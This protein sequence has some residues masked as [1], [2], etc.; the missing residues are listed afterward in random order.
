MKNILVPTDFSIFAKYAI[1][2]AHSLAKKF[3]ATVYV[4]HN[5]TLPHELASLPAEEQENHKEVLQMI[6]NANILLEET[7][8]KFKGKAYPIIRKG[9]L[10]DNINQIVP[11]KGIDMVI[12]GSHGTSGKNEFFIG[13]NTQ[14]AV[15]VVHCPVLVLKKPL[16]KLDFNTIV[17]ASSFNVDERESILKFKKFIKHFIPEIIHLLTIHTSAFFG[18]P[19]V[20]E[21]AALEDCGKLL[22]PF[23]IRNH[24][25]RD[26]TVSGGIQNFVA[27]M[28]PDLLVVSNHQRHPLKRML[29][30]S[31]VEALINHVD[32]P[33]LTIDYTLD[34]TT[35]DFEELNNLAYKQ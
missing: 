33:V 1:N 32:I 23:K 3:N 34:L 21:K 17:Y 11:E 28:K 30:G 27:K 26:F 35:E 6:H 9:K 22:K 14:K 19:F 15:R 29:R 10:I 5:V 20:L 25:Y 7:M 24:V 16:E 2:A 18:P 31:N 12:M 8:K 13:S 4:F